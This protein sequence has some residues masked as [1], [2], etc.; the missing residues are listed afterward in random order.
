M[1]PPSPPPPAAA[2]GGTAGPT[3]T[4]TPEAE[5]MRRCQELQFGLEQLKYWKNRVGELRAEHRSATLPALLQADPNQWNRLS[6]RERWK[7]STVLL[8][9]QYHSGTKELEGG[10]AAASGMQQPQPENSVRCALPVALREPNFRTEAPAALQMDRDVFLARIRTEDC[11]AYYRDGGILLYPIPPCPLHGSARQRQ[12]RRLPRSPYDPSMVETSGTGVIRRKCGE[13]GDED[14]LRVPPAL[15]NDR[16]VMLAVLE[17]YPSVLMY[18]RFLHDPSVHPEAGNDDLSNRHDHLFRHQGC[19]SHF[20]D[21]LWR[22]GEYLFAFLR[23]VA[24]EGMLEKGDRALRF[25]CVYSQFSCLLRHDPEIIYRFVVLEPTATFEQLRVIFAP[26]Q[27]G[28]GVPDV[29]AAPMLLRNNKEFVVRLL[30][31]LASASCTMSFPPTGLRAFSRRL[32][33]DRDVVLAAVRANGLCL[34]DSAI[35]RFRRDEDIVTAACE[36]CAYAVLYVHGA[37]QFR[38]KFQRDRQR[39]L[40]FFAHLRAADNTALEGAG[41]TAVKRRSSLSGPGSSA[42]QVAKFWKELPPLIRNDKEV[43]LTALL[44]RSIALEDLSRTLYY[45]REFWLYAI[46]VCPFFWYYLPARYGSDLEMIRSVSPF[47]GNDM[48]FE[49]IAR[50]PDLLTDKE[51]VLNAIR[52]DCSIMAELDRPLSTDRDVIEAAIDCSYESLIHLPESVQIMYPDLVAKAIRSCPD[53]SDI[54]QVFDLIEESLWSCRDVAYAWASKGGDFL[55]EEFPDEFEDDKELFLLIAEHNPA[56]FWCSSETLC[57]DKDFMLQVMQKN[58]L[59]IREVAAELK[60]DFEI[61]LAAFGGGESTSL[62]AT[63]SCDLPGRFDFN[64]PNDFKFITDLAKK[65]RMRLSVHDH[66]VTVILC[67]ISIDC[68]GT[69]S[70]LCLLDQGKDTSLSYKMQLA[71]YLDVPAGKELGMLRRA[72]ANLSRWGY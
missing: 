49:A 62:A 13:R 38:Q 2:S 3:A 9:F 55:H 7:K 37:I 57:K 44:A 1:P 6:K 15:Q 58:P 39:V 45:D 68:G 17:L 16:E 26:V 23:G 43:A 12:H 63:S 47:P 11:R 65:V 8:M 28:V 54:W 33:E 52:V 31:H 71:Q 41:R 42:P 24:Q 70:Q 32:R 56:D 64:D 4:A 36:Q 69:S 51:F 20:W 21:H 5:N 25:K 53:D 18:H 10:G 22:D 29:E 48:V 61:G 66:F 60:A 34:K 19:G 30:H 14:M 40:V 72:S 59:M 67:G 46:S 35:Y 27:A 50:F